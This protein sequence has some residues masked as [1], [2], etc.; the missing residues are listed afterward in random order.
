MKLS[1]LTL[2]EQVIVQLLNELQ[3]HDASAI[4]KYEDDVSEEVWNIVTN[5]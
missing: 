3:S 4:A 2:S 5:S 1:Q